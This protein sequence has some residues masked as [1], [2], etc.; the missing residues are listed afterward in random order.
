MQLTILIGHLTEKMHLA[1]CNRHFSSSTLKN[2]LKA[3]KWHKKKKTTPCQSVSP[4]HLIPPVRL[5]ASFSSDVV[6][7]RTSYVW[8][9]CLNEQHVEV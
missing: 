6:V 8:S 9:C 7:Q 1:V 5:S 2:S 3:L 4:D